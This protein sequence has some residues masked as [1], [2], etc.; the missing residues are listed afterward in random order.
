MDKKIQHN[1]SANFTRETRLFTPFS[2]CCRKVYWKRMSL[3]WA[4]LDLFYEQNSLNS[5]ATLVILLWSSDPLWRL[6]ESDK[7]C[8]IVECR[9]MYVCMC[10]VR[11]LDQIKTESKRYVVE[12]KTLTLTV[13]CSTG[14]NGSK[15]SSKQFIIKS[16]ACAFVW[17][18]VYIVDSVQFVQ[19]LPDMLLKKNNTDHVHHHPCPLSVDD[20]R[21]ALSSLSGLNNEF[22]LYI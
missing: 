5:L 18:S 12:P 6:T 16:L 13:C 14:A 9:C 21:L 4:L 8:Q 20:H 11:S 1:E 7:V 17:V 3:L 10:C 22:T 15:Q 19:M 2:K